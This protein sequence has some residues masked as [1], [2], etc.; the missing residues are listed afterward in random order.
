[1]KSA[2]RNYFREILTKYRQHKSSLE[3]TRFLETYYNMFDVNEDLINDEN[4]SLFSELKEDIKAKIDQRIAG[5][6]LKKLSYGWIK[7]A[8]AAVLLL[9]SVSIYLFSYQQ[10]SDPIAQMDHAISPGGNDAILTLANGKKIVLNDAAKGEI[11]KQPGISVSKSKDGE[12]IYTVVSS[13]DDEL[14]ENTYNTISTPKGGKYAIILSDGTKVMLNSASS[15]TFPTSFNA[16]DRRVELTGEA[17]FE[18]A[19]EKNKRFRVISG[20]QTVEVL[21]THFNVNA[22][23]DEQTIKTTL[24]EGAVK[25]FTAKKSVLIEP[26][27]QAVLDKADE[28]SMAKHLVNINKETSWINGVFSFEGDDLKSVMRQVA[29]WYDVN[30]IYEGPISEEKYFGEISRSSKLSE[31][32]KILELNNVNFDVAGKTIKVSYNQRPSSATVPKSVK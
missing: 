12:L 26:G 10:K 18:V 14:S 9:A 16:A 11:S 21:G 13:G 25:V 23:G 20:L 19:K 6:K 27:E 30:V 32:I 7:Y 4:E 17:Y 24:L 1:M 2:Y 22:Y 3:E 31:V 15:M 8:A 5:P 29:R 28:N